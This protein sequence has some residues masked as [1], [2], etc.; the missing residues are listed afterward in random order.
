MYDWSNGKESRRTQLTV[1]SVQEQAGI[2]ATKCL[3]EDPIYNED[4]KARKNHK[5]LKKSYSYLAR[6]CQYMSPIT[7]SEI[8]QKAGAI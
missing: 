1:D 3:V 2:T 6:Q 4:I 5:I 8:M 7:L